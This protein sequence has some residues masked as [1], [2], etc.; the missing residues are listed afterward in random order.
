MAVAL[1]VL[2]PVRLFPAVPA[3]AEQAVNASVC[4]PKATAAKLTFTLK[5]VGGKP[6]KL[7]DFKGKVMVLNFWATWCVPC[8]AEIPALVELQAKYAGSG[9]QVIGV[10]VDDPV[11][12]MKPFVGQY[13][14]NYPVLQALGNDSILDTYGPMVVVPATVVIRRDGRICGKHIGPVTK[15]ALETEIKGLL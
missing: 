5:D 11:E 10:S 15:E 13:K 7:A 12:K 6:V 8:R 4:D 2:A 9:L 1:A 14:I 3:A